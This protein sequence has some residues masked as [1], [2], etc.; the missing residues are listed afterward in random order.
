MLI[1]S[2]IYLYVLD[3]N[4]SADNYSMVNFTR[5]WDV[6]LISQGYLEQSASLVTTAEE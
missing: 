4:Y 1:L 6:N 5:H 2:L 3:Y